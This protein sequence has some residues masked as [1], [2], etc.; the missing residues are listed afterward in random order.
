MGCRLI[1]MYQILVPVVLLKR[2]SDVS[3]IGFYRKPI[4]EAGWLRCMDA[5]VIHG[6][7][8]RRLEICVFVSLSDCL[9][10]DLFI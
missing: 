10:V 9:F 6:K 4:E 5:R 1:I 3:K 8:D 7:S 2:L